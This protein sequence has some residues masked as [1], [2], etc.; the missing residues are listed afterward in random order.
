MTILNCIIYAIGV[1]VL[2]AIFSLLLTAATFKAF[3]IIIMRLKKKQ[4]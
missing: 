4:Q 2:F 3:D 1:A